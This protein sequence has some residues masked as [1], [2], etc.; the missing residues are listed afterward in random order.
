M[1]MDNSSMVETKGHAHTE[2]ENQFPP[3]N[4][5][6]PGWQTFLPISPPPSQLMNR[7]SFPSSI[8]HGRSFSES[9]VTHMEGQYAPSLYQATE[10]VYAQSDHAPPSPD[11]SVSFDPSQ[12]F[13]GQTTLTRSLT[14]STVASYSAFPIPP[15]FPGASN[16]YS[17]APARLRS[18]S[19]ASATST[20]RPLPVI[21]SLVEGDRH[22]PSPSR[23]RSLTVNSMLRP[24]PSVPGSTEA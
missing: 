7:T 6:P 8:I 24:L 13:S 15:G 5:N 23:K 9:T 4:P 12:R 14:V 21:P 11:A 1:D 16:I 3:D 19:V 10:L 18:S 2:G 20:L 22:S 17:Q